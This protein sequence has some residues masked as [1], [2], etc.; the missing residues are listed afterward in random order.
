MFRAIM[1]LCFLLVLTVAIGYFR[2]WFDVTPVK[3]ESGQT[4]GFHVKFNRDQIHDDK[5]AV[6]KTVKGLRDSWNEDEQPEEEPIPAEGELL[7]PD[8]EPFR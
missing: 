1:Y 7:P 3:N 5:Q 6:K 2:G 8:E 4:E